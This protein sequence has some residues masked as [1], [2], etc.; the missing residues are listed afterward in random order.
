V[1]KLR[2]GFE[3]KSLFPVLSCTLLLA[4]PIVAQKGKAQADYY[5]LGYTGDTFTGKVTAFDNEQR[6]LTLSYVKGKDTITFIAVIPDAPYEWTRNVRNERVLDFPFDKK[7]QYQVFK[8]AAFGDSS[9]AG[10]MLPET[11]TAGGMKRRPN[12]PDSNRITDFSQFMGRNITVYF[13]S[14]EQT[15]NGAKTKYNDVWRIKV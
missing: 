6:T 8:Y 14:R 9:A 7:S 10:H 4:S 3:A 2:L 11:D 15:L 1:R 12:P 13:T 5:P